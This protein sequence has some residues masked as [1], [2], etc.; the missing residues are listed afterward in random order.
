MDS[1]ARITLEDVEIAVR[2]IEKWLREQERARATLRRLARYVTTSN[3][4]EDKLVDLV[5]Q[6]SISNRAEEDGEEL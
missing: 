1:E 3:R 2:V 4:P 6:Q 5:F